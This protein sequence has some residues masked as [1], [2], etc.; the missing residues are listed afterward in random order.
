MRARKTYRIEDRLE[1]ACAPQVL[2]ERILSPHT[3]P[4]WQSEIV[5]VEGPQRIE[6]GDT[7]TGDAHLAGFKVQ[8]RSDAKRVDDSTFEEDVIVGVRMLVRYDVRPS[9]AGTVLTR[10]LEAELPGGPSGWLLSLVLRA[11]LRKMQRRLLQELIAQ[12]EAG[13]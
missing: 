3:W 5:R 9:P 6:R 10:S 11:R 12:A 1:A 13:A 7:V 4:E 2:L 8:G